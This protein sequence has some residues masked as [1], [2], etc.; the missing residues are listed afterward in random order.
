MEDASKPGSRISLKAAYRAFNARDVGRALGTMVPDVEWP[1][2]MEGGM[3]QGHSSVR[4]YW[5]RQWAMIDPHVNPVEFQLLPEGRILV[6]VHL[7]V[8]DL[9]GGILVDHAVIH[10]HRFPTPIEEM[11]SGSGT[12]L[13]PYPCFP[14]ARTL[15]S[16]EIRDAVS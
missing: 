14:C 5:T 11:E 1:N 3:V 12:Q 9:H 7:V 10:T 13:Q 15:P 16:P 8:R 6:W 4:E 2:G